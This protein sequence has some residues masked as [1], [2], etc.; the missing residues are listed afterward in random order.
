M[1]LSKRCPERT[2]VRGKCAR[3]RNY[4]EVEKAMPGPLEGDRYKCLSALALA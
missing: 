1:L 2:K 4:W 3:V